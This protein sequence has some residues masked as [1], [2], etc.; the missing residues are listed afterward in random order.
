MQDLKKTALADADEQAAQE[1]MTAIVGQLE[2][3]EDLREMTEG[4]GHNGYLTLDELDANLCP[5]G[6]DLKHIV[7]A[8]GRLVESNGV[9]AFHIS[10]LGAT[11]D[12]ACAFALPE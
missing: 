3:A 9:E 5:L 1:T 12:K 2:T 7:I 4:E 11:L 8:I 10:S 6:Y